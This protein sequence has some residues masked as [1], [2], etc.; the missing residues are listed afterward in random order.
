MTRLLINQT[1]ITQSQ[2]ADAPPRALQP[3][4]AR[5]AIQ[6]FA[7]TANN[8]TYAATGFV[9]GYWKFFP[10]GID[11]MGQVPVWGFAEVTEST[12]E[13]L[14]VG[15]R[16]YGFWPLATDWI[17]TPEPLPGGGVV[18]AA[19]HRR[20]LPPVYNRYH[21]SKPREAR[22]EALQ[23]LLQP[24]LA[25]SYLL[26]D[27]LADNAFFNAEQVIVGSASSKT[28]LGLTKFL[29]GLEGRPVKVIGLTSTGNVD[30]VEGLGACDQVVTYDEIETI[31][32]VPSVYVDMAG[33]SVVKQRLHAHLDDLLKHS[34]AVGTSHWD[35]FTPKQDLAGPKP[36]FFFAP[37]QIEKR[38]ADWGPGVIEQKIGT[39]WRQIAAS[40]GDWMDV[41]M[42]DGMEAAQEVYLDLAK[43]KAAPRDGHVV[44]L[45]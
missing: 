7:L 13:H 4:E 15:Q 32:P 10:T 14:N 21:I 2:I 33:N 36:Q 35:K 39:A 26:A 24:L 43:G 38:R 8:V 11:G 16:L 1:D 28:G 44:D 45:G 6:R 25:T 40:A 18:D 23:S 20:D 41:R 34:S 5:V 12:S 31:D 3:G 19:E 27:W 30:F 9:I 37:A 42:H 29:D 17:I 22:D